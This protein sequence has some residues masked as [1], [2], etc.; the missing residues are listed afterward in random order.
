LSPR[1]VIIAPTFDNART[2]PGLLEA[3]RAATPLDVIVVNDGCEDHTPAILSRWQGDGRIVLT[4]ERNRGKAAALHTGFAHARQLGYTHAI[5]IDTDGQH[6]PADIA[7][8]LKLSREHPAALV[9]GARSTESNYP[10]AS[11]I[12]RAI[13]NLLI[14]IESGARVA[15]SQCGLRVYP[16][17]STL[18]LK[19]RAGRFGYETEIITRIAWAGLPILEAPIRCIYHV[20]GG[21]TTHFRVGRDSASAVLM[22]V[23]LL[24]RSLFLVPP[25]KLGGDPQD[26]GTM[27]ERFLRW[28]NPMRVWRAIRGDHAERKRFAASFATGI[29]IATLP[30]F[31][32][33][34]V[35]C[36]FL[37]K[38][39]RLQPVVVI[40]AS[41]LNTPPIGTLLSLSSI[42]TGHLLLHARW[43]ELSQYDPFTHG[44]WT[45]FKRAGTEWICGS[46][47]VGAALSLASY[48]ILRWAFRVAPLAE[49]SPAHAG[50]T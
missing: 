47:V 23:A 43:P 8:L 36:L 5:T 46:I 29:Y 26:T 6:D 25:E 37:A 9:I 35:L 50:S 1:Y 27:V 24:A 2:L 34:T 45:I 16:L 44:M 39:F 15:D 20:A 28:I 30:P 40:G 49:P 10:R 4:H 11:R 38:T 3:L 17:E 7:P 33:K 21:R 18:H 31:G 19:N 42:V 12:G 14:Q 13:S 22:H 32:L 41:S 48:V